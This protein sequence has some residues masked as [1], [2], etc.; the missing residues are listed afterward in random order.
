MWRRT[1]R[2]SFA[3]RRPLAFGEQAG[4]ILVTALVVVAGLAGVIWALAR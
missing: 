3:P 4:L 2:R 1:R